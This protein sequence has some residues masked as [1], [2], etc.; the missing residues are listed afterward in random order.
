MIW[1]NLKEAE[2]KLSTNE[3]SD[4]EGFKY[5]LG[6][7]MLICIGGYAP[8]QFFLNQTVEGLD[9]ILSFSITV[10]GLVKLFKTNNLIDGKHFYN[11]LFV[12]SWVIGWRITVYFI[13][14]IVIIGDVFKKV[15]G[16][17]MI[18]RDTTSQFIQVAVYNLVTIIY[19]MLIYN[20][21]KRLNPP[22]NELQP[23]TTGNPG[24]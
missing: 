14:P 7:A 16:Y 17:S 5:L 23:S 19:F 22:L 8:A 3:L 6:I 13:M 11:R 15:Y 12:V 24:H 4:S 20:S 10:W 21:F 1:L 2:R 18:P 9:F